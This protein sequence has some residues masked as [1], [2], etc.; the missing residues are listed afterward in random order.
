MEKGTNRRADD[1]APESGYD[2]E[3]MF[4]TL[5]MDDGST[6]ETR[7]L[8]I[9]DTGD[10]EQN[11]IA[12]L[13]LNE[14]GTDNEDGIVYLYRYFEDGD[15]NPSL[16]NIEDDAEYETASRCFDDLMDDVVP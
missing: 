14:D 12:L 7:I 1:P 5:N 10:Q 4:V 9:F 8:T 15:G 6:V 2:E 11:Y 13:P 3:D 16:E